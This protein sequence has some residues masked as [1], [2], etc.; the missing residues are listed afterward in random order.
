MAGTEGLLAANTVSNGN[1]PQVHP[2]TVDILGKALA[3]LMVICIGTS[4]ERVRRGGDQRI[5]AVWTL[6]V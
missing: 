1:V 6:E 3:L 2:R 5:G 4:T